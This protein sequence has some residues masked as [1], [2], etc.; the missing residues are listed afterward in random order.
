HKAGPSFADADLIGV[1]F[2]LVVS[3]RN[4]AQGKV[5]LRT[6]DGSLKEQVDLADVAQR[7]RTLVD[8]AYD[9]YR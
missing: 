8:Q 9:A 6:R 7:V 3:P 5:E 2:R 4:L 1:P